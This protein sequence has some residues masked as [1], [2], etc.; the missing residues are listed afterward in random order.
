MA[1][2]MHQ[3]GSASTCLE[4]PIQLNDVSDNCSSS[5]DKKHASSRPAAEMLVA[6]AVMSCLR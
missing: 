3:N 5:R 4:Q 6:K 1:A 2:A